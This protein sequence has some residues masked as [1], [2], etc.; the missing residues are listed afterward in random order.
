MART[1]GQTPPKRKKFRST[2]RVK[3]SRRCR[4]DVDPKNLGAQGT[5]LPNFLITDKDIR[6]QKPEETILQDNSR[7]EWL[8]DRSS[9]IVQLA[10]ATGNF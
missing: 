7:N 2:T 10:K 3:H 1:T 4:T 5:Y 8:S 6:D 9:K